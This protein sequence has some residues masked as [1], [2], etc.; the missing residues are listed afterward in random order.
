MTHFAHHH[1]FWTESKL[2]LDSAGASSEDAPL[3]TNERTGQ[4]LAWTENPQLAHDN[5]TQ[6]NF[7]ID[8]D[9]NVSAVGSHTELSAP[10]E[11]TNTWQP[12]SRNASGTYA[13][14]TVPDMWSPPS[15]NASLQT[16]QPHSA[17]KR[18]GQ[19]DE[20]GFSSNSDKCSEIKPEQKKKNEKQA[21]EIARAQFKQR[22]TKLQQSQLEADKAVE[23]LLASRQQLKIRMQ[24]QVLIAVVV[25]FLCILI[26]NSVEGWGFVNCAYF[27]VVSITTVGRYM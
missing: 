2:G 3:L 27:A 24:S 18:K 17:M 13:E 14:S 10:I 4:S 20:R 7:S 8:S 5:K 16:E 23:A 21:R 25:L 26:Y 6:Q 15:R 19:A 11:T 1:E 9:G 22:Q 12:P